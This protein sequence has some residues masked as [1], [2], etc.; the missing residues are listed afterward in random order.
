MKLKFHMVHDQ[1]PRLKNSKFKSGR[2]FKMAAVTRNSKT[3]KIA[4]FSRTARYILL[5]FC[6]ENTLDL[7]VN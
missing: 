5:K 7:D 2:E 4:I 3:N 6:M 1:I